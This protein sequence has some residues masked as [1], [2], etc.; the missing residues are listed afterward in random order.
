MINL[1]PVSLWANLWF[2]VVGTTVR[3]SLFWS[4]KDSELVNSLR[5]SDLFGSRLG[6]RV[7]RYSVLR[8]LSIKI[9]F[10]WVV[11]VSIRLSLFEL[12]LNL[13]KAFILDVGSYSSDTR[14]PIWMKLW[15]V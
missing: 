3:L 10:L 14:G 6:H 8:S 13:K 15:G 12:I 2:L 7:G 4:I 9:R 1:S 5:P 11:G